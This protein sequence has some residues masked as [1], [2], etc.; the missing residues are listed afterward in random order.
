MLP[1][2][3]EV[4]RRIT[5]RAARLTGYPYENIE[6]LQLVKYLDG[7]KYEPHFDYGEA[8]KLTASRTAPAL[9]QRPP[10]ELRQLCCSDR[11]SYGTGL[12]TAEPSQS[13]AVAQPRVAIALA[14]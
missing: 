14:R 3:D 10:G 5:E 1:A 4:V 9:P 12:A 13:D 7:Q 8:C 6:P 11:H 2:H